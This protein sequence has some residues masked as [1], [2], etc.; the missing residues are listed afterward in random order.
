V[1]FLKL[2]LAHKAVDMPDHMELFMHALGF[3]KEAHGSQ[4]IPGSDV[5]YI[6][7]PMAV[8][9]ILK[10]C[11]T[12]ANAGLL[13]PVALLHDTIEDTAV[14]HADLVREFGPAVADGVLALS[15]NSELPK[16]QRMADSI[17]RIQAQPRPIWMVKM[18]DRIVNLQPPPHF[19]TEKKIESYRDEAKF[20]LRELGSADEYFANLLNQKIGD[21]PGKLTKNLKSRAV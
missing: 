4:T 16:P 2:F 7:H 1:N 5:P 14:T 3:A 13:L 12:V 11:I 17:K 19:W 10:P 21:Y 8:S 20:I 6:V 15:K 18:A 9:E